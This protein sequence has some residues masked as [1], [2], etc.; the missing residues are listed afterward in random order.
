MKSMF[1][2]GASICIT[3][4]FC[5]TSCGNNGNYSGPAIDAADTSQTDSLVEE[6]YG[7]FEAKAVTSV[8]ETTCNAE[9]DKVPSSED[10]PIDPAA[11]EETDSKTDTYAASSNQADSADAT[12]ETIPQLKQA[13]NNVFD[14][15][16]F[17][18]D[19]EQ[20]SADLMDRNM[21]CAYLYHTQVLFHYEQPSDEYG[22]YP[23][24]F[25]LFQNFEEYESFIRAT[26][27]KATAD[28]LLY[29]SEEK[30]PIFTEKNGE[31]FYNPNNMGFT[32]GPYFYTGYMIKNFDNEETVCSFI[33]APL[34][35]DRFTEKEYS[36][37]CRNWDE[38]FEHAC[39]M[40]LEDG[41]WRLS[42]LIGAF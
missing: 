8:G 4:I 10:T 19:V 2:T 6:L 9:K 15:G 28:S 22:C 11:Q 17:V 33:Y 37:L 38:T 36:E 27:T 32:V 18:Y 25:L 3:I 41:E 7:E 31:I 13:I 42:E 34:L 5:L 12:W 39:Q 14:T 16:Y 35:N 23:A 30:G 21:I 20:K 26:Y 24:D 40:V 1:K 29:G